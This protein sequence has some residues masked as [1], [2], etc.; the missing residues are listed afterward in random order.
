MGRPRGDARDEVVRDRC[1]AVCVSIVVAAFVFN[2]VVA[3][4]LKP[5]EGE[6]V[7]RTVREPPLRRSL[8]PEE[9]ARA[10]DDALVRAVDVGGAVAN[11]V[12]ND[13]FCD[14]AATA[15]AAGRSSVEVGRPAPERELFSPRNPA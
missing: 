14:A 13:A 4:T 6:P 3:V 5:V 8:R 7:V 11:F 9:R 10:L 1:Y 12:C 15:L 2:V